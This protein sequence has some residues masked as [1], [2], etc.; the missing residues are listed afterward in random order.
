MTLLA[1]NKT[2]FN[3]PLN[4]YLTSLKSCLTDKMGLKVFRVLHTFK[5]KESLERHMSIELILIVNT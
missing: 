2:S 5:T 4:Y 3:H 1:K